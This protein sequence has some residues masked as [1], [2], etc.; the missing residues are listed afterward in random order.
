MSLAGVQARGLQRRTA[1]LLV[2]SKQCRAVPML[3]WSPWAGSAKIGL[4]GYILTARR[5]GDSGPHPGN[6]E[7]L[8]HPLRVGLLLF[9]VRRSMFVLSL[10]PQAKMLRLA[11]FAALL[12]FFRVSLELSWA[13][14]I[15][16][17]FIFYLGSGGWDFFLIFIKTIRRDVT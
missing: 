7:L 15:P 13:Q 16:A 17:L 10:S 5:S 6:W 9:S 3:N 2:G 12:L 1:R 8:M 14:A 11:A 4:L